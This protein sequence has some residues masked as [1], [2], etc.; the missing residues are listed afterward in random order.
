MPPRRRIIPLLSVFGAS[1]LCHWSALSATA[2][3]P[4]AAPVTPTPPVVQEPIPGAAPDPATPPLP[5][6]T[7][8]W[9]DEF[10]YTGHP[11]AAKWDYEEGY[12]RNGEK[13]FYTRARLENARVEN[14]T[15]VL[16]GRKD[17][18]DI[19]Q[20]RGRTNG[21][22]IADYTSA[23]LETKTKASWTYGRIEVR[24][25]LPQGKGVW[26]AAWTLGTNVGVRSVGWPACGEIDIMEF[27]GKVPGIIYGTTHYG[28]RKKH[29]ANG[30]QFKVPQLDSAFH[31]F[32]A[33]WNPDRI[34]FSCDG[35]KY[36]SFDVSKAG[37]GEENPF[38]KPH[39]L[40]LNLALG[41]SW[42]GAIDDAILPQQYRIDYVRV[43]K[44]SG[45]L[46]AA[47]RP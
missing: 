11:D 23:S 34:E 35:K 36:H 30:Q 13:Q 31:V 40:I 46:P 19:S 20:I 28:D 10:N 42:G 29:K 32:A 3:P 41:G 18:F 7:L 26:P 8:V 17:S 6:W 45:P 15:L 39:F 37:D 21:K 38:R 12:I 16:E 43:Y 33:E 14:G 1:L 9:S 22:K 2:Q 5:G 4:P 47:G 27:V 25:R 44:R 24:A